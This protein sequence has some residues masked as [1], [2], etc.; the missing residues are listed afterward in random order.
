[1]AVI[2]CCARQQFDAA[3]VLLKVTGSF[4]KHKPTVVL[5][6]LFVLF[7]GS[8]Y[9]IFWIGTLI[10]IQLSRPTEENTQAIEA[11]NPNQ[12]KFVF[13]DLMTILWV[14]FNIFYTYFLYY[15][16]VFLIATATAIWYYNIEGNYLLKGLKYIFN[17]H[18][19]SFTFASM[20]AAIISM[21]RSST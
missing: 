8:F 11:N 10:A 5:A 20:I 4:I 3:I 13:Q 1:M 6:P 7:I 2:F 12:I 18:I 14:F 16:M 15:V 19:G 17:A 21:I 9:F